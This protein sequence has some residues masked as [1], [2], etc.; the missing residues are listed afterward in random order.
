MFNASG[1]DNW[2]G[3]GP[4][5]SGNTDDQDCAM[6]KSGS[7]HGKWLIKDCNG[8]SLNYLCEI[9]SGNKSPSLKS[10]SIVL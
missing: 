7:S 9:R 3:N 2:E 5:G 8:D 1:F 4:S 6:L 10:N